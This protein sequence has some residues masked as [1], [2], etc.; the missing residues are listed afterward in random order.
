MKFGIVKKAALGAVVTGAS[1]ATCCALALPASAATAGGPWGSGMPST[2]SS[3]SILNNLC[4]APWQWN[5]PGEGLTAGHKAAYAACNGNSDPGAGSS[6]SILNNLCVA[7]WQWN[8]PV[9]ALTGGHEADYAACNGN[10]GSAAGSSV[11]I[12]NNLC[13]A[14]WQWN[15]PGEGLTAGHKASY[16]A[17]NGNGGSS[18]SSSS[19]AAA[20]SS[21]AGSGQDVSILGNPCVAPWQWNGP[22]EVLTIGHKAAYAACNGN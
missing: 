11:S 1:L 20:S 7:P 18:S 8:G 12:L 10:G 5:G 16:A 13:V 17:C 4:V 6:V 14:P 9:E 3:V 19:S 21:F 22:L 2:G 15:G